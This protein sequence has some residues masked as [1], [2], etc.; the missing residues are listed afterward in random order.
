MIYHDLPLMPSRMQGRR[1]QDATDLEGD[2][3]V[4]LACGEQ[5]LELRLARWKGAEELRTADV[6]SDC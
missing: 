2:G 3:F 1:W 5:V 6:A 4:G